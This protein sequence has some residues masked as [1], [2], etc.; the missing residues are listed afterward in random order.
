MLALCGVFLGCIG[1]TVLHFQLL[2]LCVCVVL[3]KN[4]R[5]LLICQSVNLPR[6]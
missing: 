4:E 2:F 6:V 5:E 1:E 3:Q